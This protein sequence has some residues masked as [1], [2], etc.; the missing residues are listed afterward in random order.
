MEQVA[1]AGIAEVEVV[2][3]AV[4]NGTLIKTLREDAKIGI[5]NE[6][7]ALKD[8]Y[9]RMRP[10]DPPTVI[11]AKQMIHKLFFELAHYDLGYVGR[12]HELAQLRPA[13]EVRNH[14]RERLRVD[15]ARRASFALWPHLPDRDA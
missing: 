7:D 5:H 11:N 15:E 8:I 3:V 9:K 13:E 6:E 12:V 10:G 1:A 4:D 14:R 2:D